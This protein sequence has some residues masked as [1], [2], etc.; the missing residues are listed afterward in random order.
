MKYLIILLIGLQ[1]FAKPVELAVNEQSLTCS[2]GSLTLKAAG[3]SQL[4]SEFKVANLDHPCFFRIY[5]NDKAAA[6]GGILSS[7]VQVTRA[8]VKEPIYKCAP[9][10]CPFCDP[11]DCQIVGH[12]DVVEESVYIDILGLLFSAKSKIT[13]P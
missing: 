10:P 4:V 12:R 5:L 8:T 9:R 6:N 2:G 1:T 13:N 7:D 3:I 11:G